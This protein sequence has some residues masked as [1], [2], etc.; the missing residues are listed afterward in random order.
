[1]LETEIKNKIIAVSL[2]KVKIF[3][4]HLSHCTEPICRNC[5][6]FIKSS[7]LNLKGEYD[8]HIFIYSKTYC[9][10]DISSPTNDLHI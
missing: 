3:G 10:E 1:M 2:N 8:I 9:V 7:N 6:M 4:M 5:K